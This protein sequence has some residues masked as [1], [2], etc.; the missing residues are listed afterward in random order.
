[1]HM[2][3]SK[4]IPKFSRLLEN[5]VCGPPPIFPRDILEDSPGL[6]A[7]TPPQA[8]LVVPL[9]GFDRGWCGISWPGVVRNPSV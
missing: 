6:P 7:A 8:V 9:F 4:S 5:M 3:W 1:M 2:R